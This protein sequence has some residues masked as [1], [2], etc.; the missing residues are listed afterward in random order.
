MPP[1]FPILPVLVR[2]GGIRAVYC[3]LAHWAPKRGG[4][5]L[6]LPFW[7]IWY[8]VFFSLLTWRLSSPP[9]TATTSEATRRFLRGLGFAYVALPALLASLT[10]GW[11]NQRALSNTS[12]RAFL[13]SYLA[14]LVG[15]LLA[16]FSSVGYLLLRP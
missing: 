7:A 9:V 4:W 3:V 11:G 14:G 2:Y 6:V 13:W 1:S 15:R 8:G 5:R 16:G 10:L 12:A